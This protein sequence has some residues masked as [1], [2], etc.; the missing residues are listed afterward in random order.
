MEARIVDKYFLLTPN[1]PA[2]SALLKVQS[3]RL[4]LRI[5][6]SRS[7]RGSAA[8]SSPGAALGTFL[9]PWASPALST[10]ARSST[11]GDDDSFSPCARRQ[12]SPQR[13]NDSS[14]PLSLHCCRHIAV[15]SYFA[16][17]SRVNDSSHRHRCTLKQTETGQTSMSAMRCITN[18][19]TAVVSSSNEQ[20]G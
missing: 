14:A 18:F 6:E 8:P 7:C 15:V 9:C 12:C 4:R 16:L 5:C 20:G 1:S 11:R 2:R 13:A 17:L 10:S 19:V 3:S